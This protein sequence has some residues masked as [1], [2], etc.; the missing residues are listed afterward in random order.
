MRNAGFTGVRLLDVSPTTVAEQRGTDWMRFDSLT[1]A[2]DPE[3]PTRTVEGHPA[4]LRA[5]V[6]GEIQV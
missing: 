6:L 5:A 2:L 4:P 1:Q 3:D